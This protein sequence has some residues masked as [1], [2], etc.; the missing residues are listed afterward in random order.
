MSE[1]EIRSIKMI[2]GYY[3]VEFQLTD[4]PMN[5]MVSIPIDLYSD[6]Y[7]QKMIRENVEGMKKELELLKRI[8]ADWKGKKIPLDYD[9][10]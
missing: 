3:H 2:P 9:K 1:I 5:G 6:E 10:S 8:I 7:M 4:L